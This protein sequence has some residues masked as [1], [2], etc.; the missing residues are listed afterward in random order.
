M[1]GKKLSFNFFPFLSLP[2][3][4]L[5]AS[6]IREFEITTHQIFNKELRL[7]HQKLDSW[8]WLG[9]FCLNKWDGWEEEHLFF[10]CLRIYRSWLVQFVFFFFC[11]FVIR[12]NVFS[13]V[14]YC[15]LWSWDSCEGVPNPNPTPS[16]YHNIQMKMKARPLPFY[17]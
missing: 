9:L 5:T 2:W 8:L 12:F 10:L 3:K 15:S 11:L 16:K 4:P 17:L 1:K 6:S 7:R 14:I 13:E